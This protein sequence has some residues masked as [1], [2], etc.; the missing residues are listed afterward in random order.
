M[1]SQTQKPR[2]HCVGSRI[3]VLEARSNY[4]K[5]V[6]DRC[7]DKPMEI[8]STN[9]SFKSRN[10]HKTGQLIVYQVVHHKKNSHR[11]PEVTVTRFFWSGEACKEPESFGNRTR[12]WE[13]INRQIYDQWFG[14]D[15]PLM[16]LS[17]GILCRCIIS[18]Q[19]SQTW[20]LKTGMAVCQVNSPLFI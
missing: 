12:D 3:C 20:I 6:Y 10:V 16:P 4:F 17:V 1:V 5:P 19:W 7:R 15:I 14:L 8:R 13:N 9:S 11:L 18:F 2:T